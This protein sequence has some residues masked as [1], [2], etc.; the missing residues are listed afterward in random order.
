MFS[1]FSQN[2]DW[3]YIVGQ[4]FRTHC[5]HTPSCFQTVIFDVCFQEPRESMLTPMS[6]HSLSQKKK[7]TS[8]T[9]SDHTVPSCPRQTNPGSPFPRTDFL[10]MCSKKMK[11]VWCSI[12]KH[13]E[14]VWAVRIKREAPSPS[15]F[16][17]FHSSLSAL[18][19]VFVHTHANSL[20]SV[21]AQS[22]ITTTNAR[23]H[24]YTHYL[25][26]CK[27][28]LQANIYNVMKNSNYVDCYW[29]ALLSDGYVSPWVSV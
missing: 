5:N 10:E 8:T 12:E 28:V 27:W 17:L 4:I 3:Y 23:T 25:E 22:Q 29:A 13:R 26:S 2:T 16:L 19:H 24:T 7:K 14:F 6:L 18:S 15:L 1:Q 21:H 11:C 20:H 9:N